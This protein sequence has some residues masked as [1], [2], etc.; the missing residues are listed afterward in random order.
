MYYILEIFHFIVDDV[1][2]A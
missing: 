2:L 1:D